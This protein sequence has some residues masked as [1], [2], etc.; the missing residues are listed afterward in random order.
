MPGKFLIFYQRLYIRHLTTYSS[1][2]N[3]CFSSVSENKEMFYQ[4]LV[5]FTDGDGTFSMY[6]QK[7]SWVLSYQ[8]GQSTYNLKIL[9]FIKKELGVGKIYITKWL[10]LKYEILKYRTKLSLLYLI[11]ILY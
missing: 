9:C 7:N 10:I 5:G 8:L 2:S 11:Y 6:R 4:W 3:T 1:I